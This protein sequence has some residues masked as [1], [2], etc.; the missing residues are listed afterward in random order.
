MTVAA[1][2]KQFPNLG[3]PTVL[4]TTKVG[5]AKEIIVGQ[6]AFFKEESAMLKQEPIADLKTY[7]RWHLVSSLTSALPKEYVR[8]QLPCACAYR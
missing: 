8:L 3:L 2:N 6:P 4:Q 5:A 1:F 7:M